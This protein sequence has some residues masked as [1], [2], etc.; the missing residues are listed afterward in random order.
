MLIVKSCTPVDPYVVVFVS[1]TT[2]ST[3]V[4]VIVSDSEE[5]VDATLGT[6]LKYREDQEKVR[7]EGLQYLLTIAAGA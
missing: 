3:V 7:G 5:T 4:I 1:C 2:T 6:L